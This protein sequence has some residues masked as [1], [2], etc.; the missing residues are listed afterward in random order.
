MASQQERSGY[1]S[2]GKIFLDTHDFLGGVLNTL[3][4]WNQ[5]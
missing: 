4:Y 1:G 2:Q 5:S 3:G